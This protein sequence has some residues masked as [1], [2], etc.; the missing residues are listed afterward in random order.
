MKTI[1]RHSR[2]G[3]AYELVKEQGNVMIL[4]LIGTDEQLSLPKITVNK[5]YTVESVEGTEETITAESVETQEEIKDQEPKSVGEE[6]LETLQ[7][8]TKEDQEEIKEEIKEET[9][10][11]IKEDQEPVVEEPK[12]EIKKEIKKSTRG[13]KAKSTL[14]PEDATC[15]EKELE[16]ITVKFY[17]YAA[18]D[19][20]FKTEAVI[21][22]QGSTYRLG[23]IFKN[24]NNKAFSSFYYKDDSSS[25]LSNVQ[26]KGIASAA[27]MLSPVMGIDQAILS[28]IMT[29]SRNLE[30]YR[31]EGL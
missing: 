1:Y 21:E 31:G 28:M 23:S 11:E 25:E 27:A 6:V 10:E 18:S 8:I 19:T 30:I 24:E 12:K 3:K 15:I 22:S 17:E 14:I 5:W 9:K 7:E 2:T 4:Q 29:E 16:G 13:K 26:R 20:T